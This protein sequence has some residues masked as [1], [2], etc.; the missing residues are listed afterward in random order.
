MFSVEPVKYEIENISPLALLSSSVLVSTFFYGIVFTFAWLCVSLLLR[1]SESRTPLM[2]KFFV[3]YVVL[4][5]ALSTISEGLLIHTFFSFLLTSGVSQN[6]TTKGPGHFLII[7]YRPNPFPILLAITSLLVDCLMLWRCTVISSSLT[8]RSRYIIFTL[9]A[10]LIVGSFLSTIVLVPLHMAVVTEVVKKASCIWIAAPFL[11]LS[12]IANFYLT[13]FVVIYLSRH[14]KRIREALG[15]RHDTLY[16]RV[17]VILVESF[18]PI[19]FGTTVYFTLWFVITD[20]SFI[21]EFSQVHIYAIS[22]LLLLMQV[23]QQK[24][25][26]PPPS[27][28]DLS[29]VF[30]TN[31]TTSNG[32]HVA[33]EGGP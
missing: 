11:G 12:S 7:P 3:T 8:R 19:V 2:T 4:M 6:I 18:A 1:T 32:V 9:P 27:H 29:L 16:R 22:P 25:L 30:A 24:T 23:A 20:A 13:L 31:S 14:R 26:P 33:K 10:I 21:V 5:F 28:H 17:N 15:P